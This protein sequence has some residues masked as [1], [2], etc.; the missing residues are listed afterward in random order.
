MRFIRY[1]KIF[2][3]KRRKEAVN[4]E[5]R[6]KQSDFYHSLFCNGKEKNRKARKKK[7]V[8]AEGGREKMGCENIA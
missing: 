1:A 8:G 5:G 4:K 6:K 3:V 7:V 2:Y